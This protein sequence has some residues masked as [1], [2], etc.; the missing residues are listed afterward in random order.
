V[1]QR[2]YLKYHVNLIF[3]QKFHCLIVARYCLLPYCSA[4]LLFILL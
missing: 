3:L 1:V 4:L 2:I